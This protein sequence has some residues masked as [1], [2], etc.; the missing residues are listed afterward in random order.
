MKNNYRLLLIPMLCFAACAAPPVETTPM[1]L[2]A[3]LKGAEGCSLSE[4]PFRYIGYNLYKYINGGAEVYHDY[5]FQRVVTCTLVFDDNGEEVTVDFCDMGTLVD[6]YGLFTMLR[7]QKG[8]HPEAGTGCHYSDPIL[9]MHK[10][11]FLI[12]LTGAGSFPGLQERLVKLARRI[13]A[14]IPDPAGLPKEL[15]LLPEKNRLWNTERYRKKQVMGHGFLKEAWS[16][17]YSMPG[18]PTEL[19]II[20]LDSADDAQAAL[21]K[22]ASRMKG[23]TCYDGAFCGSRGSNL[24]LIRRDGSRLVYVEGKRIDS[25]K[26]LSFEWKP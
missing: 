19:A 24:Y 9:C 4:G 13:A 12:Q 15:E 7:P 14:A 25:M 20:C 17:K 26:K 10:G 23:E 11:K 2:F 22:F 21:E 6:A 16:A 8:G 1:E 3:S 18:G 5:N